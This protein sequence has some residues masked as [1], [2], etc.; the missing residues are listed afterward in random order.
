[1]NVDPDLVHPAEMISKRKC[2][3]E[4]DEDC[5]GMGE[6]THQKLYLIML[7]T[8]ASQMISSKICPA[9]RGFQGMNAFIINSNTTAVVTGVRVVYL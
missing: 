4:L 7:R 3:R 6:I 5:R 2:S 1:M 8:F 9:W